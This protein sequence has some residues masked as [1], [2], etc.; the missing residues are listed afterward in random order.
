MFIPIV[1]TVAMPALFVLLTRPLYSFGVDQMIIHMIIIYSSFPI[2]SLLPTFILQ[3]DPDTEVQF[4][5]ASITIIAT[6]ISMVTIPFWC[7]IVQTV[8]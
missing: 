1:R 7:Y 6:M 5:A 3:Y 8:A 4:E 2:A